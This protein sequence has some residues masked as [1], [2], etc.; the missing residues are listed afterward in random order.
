MKRGYTVSGWVRRTFTW[1]F[2]G[3][4]ILAILVIVVSAASITASS[5]NYQAELGS[6]YNVSNGLLVGDKGFSKPS[7]GAGATGACPTANVTFGPSPG[8]ANN[9]IVAGDIVYDVQVNATGTTPLVSC[10]TVTLTLSIGGTQTTKSLNIA[11]GSSVST[12]QAIDCK[13]DI[14][15][16]SLPLSPFSFRLTVQ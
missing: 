2:S 3:K 12:G 4:V 7:V 16:T 10:F 6:A 1:Y 5:T 8:S 11:S 9:A 14:G 13:L 15:T